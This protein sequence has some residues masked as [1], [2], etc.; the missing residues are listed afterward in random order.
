MSQDS[1]ATPAF[2]IEPATPAELKPGQ[3]PR[4]FL[5]C[6]MCDAR[7]IEI[8]YNQRIAVDRAYHCVECQIDLGLEAH[9]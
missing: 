2:R 6:S 4:V 3:K 9:R 1:R 5:H 8:A 7:L